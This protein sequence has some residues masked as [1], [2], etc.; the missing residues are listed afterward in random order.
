MNAATWGRIGMFVT[1]FALEFVPSGVTNTIGV[2]LMAGDTPIDQAKD[3]NSP[4]TIPKPETPPPP[5]KKDKCTCTTEIT[6]I[7]LNAGTT[8]SAGKISASGNTCPEAQQKLFQYAQDYSAYK[9]GRN[10]TGYRAKH[11]NKTQCVEH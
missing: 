4:Q 6:I 3:E 8:I 9:R 10:G 7:D 1:G 5:C 11:I 2:A